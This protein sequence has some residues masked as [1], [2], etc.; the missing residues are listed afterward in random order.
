[1]SKLEKDFKEKTGQ[2]EEE[3][4]NAEEKANEK[5]IDKVK[6]EMAGEFG[7]VSS[8]GSDSEGEESD[9]SEKKGKDDFEFD[10]SSGIESD[11]GADMLVEQE[12]TNLMRRYKEKQKKSKEERKA[13]GEPVE[14]EE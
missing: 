1:M 14:E 2:V 6:P 7:L 8:S 10:Y 3:K 5:T 4:G 12:V 9:K 13:K 11:E